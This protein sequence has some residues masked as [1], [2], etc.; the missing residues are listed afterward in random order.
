MQF[1]MIRS[2]SSSPMCFLRI[3]RSKTIIGSLR[4]DDAPVYDAAGNDQVANA[5]AR[6]STN[7][8]V[9]L[10]RGVVA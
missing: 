3:R 8:A 9:T 10:R 7:S 4:F 1:H 6:G 2:F 5:H